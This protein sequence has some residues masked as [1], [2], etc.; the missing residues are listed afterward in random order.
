MNYDQKNPMT[1]A[2]LDHLLGVLTHIVQMFFFTLM[3]SSTVQRLLHFK[4]PWKC[5]NNKGFLT[6]SGGIV[7]E[8]YHRA[9]ESNDVNENI[10][11]KLVNIK[12]VFTTQK[13]KFSNKDFFSKCQQFR[14]FIQIW[15]HLLKKSLMEN[16][17]FCAVF[18]WWVTDESCCKGK[19]LKSMK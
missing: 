6:F 1:M 10:G 14:S 18:C 12:L 13:L 5:Q 16:F 17:S 15:S 11:T 4:T 2:W 8:Y 7:M 9:L 19:K 3:L